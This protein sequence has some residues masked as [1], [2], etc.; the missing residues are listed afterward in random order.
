MTKA[1][2]LITGGAGFIGSHL[3]QRL[4]RAGGRVRVL[5]S[6]DAF[7]DVAIKRR[8][9]E[10]TAAVLP[11]RFEFVEGDIRDA[12]V[13]RE[14]LRDI[15]VVVHLAA[16]AGVRPSIQ[17]PV[18]YMDVNVTGT[19]TLL[20]QIHRPETVFVFGSSSSVYGG[21][22][23]VPFAETDPVD[24]PVSPY[25]ASK[26]A[27]EVL[28][29]AWHHLRGNPVACLRFFTVYGPRQRPEMAIHQFAR[30]ITNGTEIPFFGD[31]TSRRDYTYVDDIV[32]GVVAAMNA[33]RPYAIYNLGGAAVTSLSELVALLERALGR[34]ARRKQLPDQPGDVPVTFADVGLAEKELG[35]R[36]TTPIASGIEKFCAWYVDEKARGR[37]A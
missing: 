29:H 6:L 3:G 10:Q 8:N 15:D 17:D 35:Y 4:L 2:V 33:P 22:R 19:Q 31:G 24:H 13:C 9:L 5:D 21:N 12:A 30:H 25:A 16:L 20:Q 23:K 18:R 34:P 28:C 11:D 26:K 32:E 14:A 1:T 7:Y 27:G 36:C 37:V